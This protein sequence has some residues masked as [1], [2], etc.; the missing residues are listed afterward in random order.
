MHNSSPQLFS[1]PPDEWQD[2]W[3]LG[4]SYN[5]LVPGGYD[6]RQTNQENPRYMGL[7]AQAI[8]EGEDMAECFEQS[9]QAYRYGDGARA[10][11]LSNEGH[12]CRTMMDSLNKQASDWIFAENNKDRNPE[13]I[14]LH[15]LYVP[16]AINRTERAIVQAMQRGDTEIRLIVGQ[17][18]HSQY[19]CAKIKPAI[20]K[21]VQKYRLVA[22]P[23]VNN[24]GVI[25][26]MLY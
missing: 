22:A 17:G 14:D 8:Q 5:Y 18:N 6:Q 10:K 25:I 9:Q 15:D 1:G 4:Q 12:A 13:E 24:A 11:R 16:E 19:R 7:R 21:L 23:D 2:H 26:V 3:E 20:Q